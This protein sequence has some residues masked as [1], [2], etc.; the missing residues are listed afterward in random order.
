MSL[1]EALWRAGDVERELVQARARLTRLQGTLLPP[2]VTAGLGL[3][4][5]PDQRAKA[6]ELADL[7]GQALVAAGTALGKLEKELGGLHPLR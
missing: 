2:I 6:M 4:I 3:Y 1:V 5:S 7:L